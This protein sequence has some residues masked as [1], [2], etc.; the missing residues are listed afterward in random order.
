MAR[1]AEVDGRVDQRLHHEEDVGRAGP[2]DRGRHGDEALVVDL[3][4]VAEGREQRAGLLALRLGGLRGRVPDGHA[5]AELGRRVGHAPDDLAV[6]EMAHQRPGRR[7]REDADHELARPQPTSDL[8]PDPAQHLGLDPE[9]HDVGAL[10]RSRVQVDRPDAVGPL[11]GLAPVAAGMA[12]DDLAGRDDVVAEQA[13]DDRLGHD[14]GA[15]GRDRG[16]RER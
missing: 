11:E 16:A 5:L 13:G 2:G 8:A 12:G 7:A 10:D 9:Q 6:A 4:L 3:D 14:A 15:D 1:E